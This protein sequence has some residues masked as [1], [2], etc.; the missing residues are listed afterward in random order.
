MAGFGIVGAGALG[1]TFA[2]SLAASGQDVTL[3]ATARSAEALRAAGAI[4]VHGAIE[5]EIG[6][7]KVRV[8]TDPADLPDGAGVIF[9]TKG[10]QLPGAIADV[11]RGWPR[12]N[13]PAAWVAGIQ[14]G[15][16]KDELLGKAFGPMRVVGAVTIVGC[17][18]EA[19]GSVRVTGRGGT[20]LGDLGQQPADSPR[21][22]AAVAALDGAG[23]P[24]EAA[25]DIAS[26]LWS[27]L[28]NATGL[29]GVTCLSRVPSGR[30]GQHPELVR[31]FLTLVWETAEVARAHNVRVGDYPGFPI[32]T[33]LARTLEENLAEFAS[34]PVSDATTSMHNDLLAGRPLEVDAIFADVVKRAEQVGVSVP[35]LTLVRDL[36]TAIDPAR[37]PGP[38]E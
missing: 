12:P 30:L 8:A 22:R 6:L 24:T 35:A 26:V 37:Q 15:I 28:C 34:R 10:H 25:R 14:N 31:S 17:V 33:Y 21:V 11:K 27:K 18:R 5:L 23:L 32:A 36:M 7:E 29:F 13:D 20:W 19:D 3:F 9:T 2:A 1:Q 16:V 38:K 4:R